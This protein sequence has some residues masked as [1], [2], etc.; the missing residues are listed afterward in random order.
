MIFEGFARRFTSLKSGKN[1]TEARFTHLEALSVGQVEPASY[2]LTRA[3][4][5]FHVAYNG[6]APT[7]IAPV[8]VLPTT[9]AQWALW[10]PD[11][12]KSLVF[13]VLGAFPLSGTPGV[14]GQLLGAHFGAPAQVGANATGMAVASL[15]TKGT[16]GVIVK[17]GV[18]ITTPAAGLWTPIAETGSANVGAFPG[19]GIIVNRAL[20]GRIVVPP[21][22]GYALAVMALAGTTPLFGPIAEWV[23]IEADLEP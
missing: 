16:S 5:R 14:G 18:T 13:E 1:Q 2:E 19:S 17:S 8:Q 6:T 7:G 11:Q 22:S 12:F 3:G 15:N 21:L 9:A 4:R 20:A 23:E 10:N